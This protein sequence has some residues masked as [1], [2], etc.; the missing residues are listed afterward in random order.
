MG[1]HI[2]IWGTPILLNKGWPKKS[3]V[4]QGAPRR[5]GGGGCCLNCSACVRARWPKKPILECISTFCGKEEMDFSPSFFGPP[6]RREGGVPPE[7][8]D[9]LHMRML[10]SL[11]CSARMDFLSPPLGLRA[12]LYRQTCKNP[13]APLDTLALVCTIMLGNLSKPK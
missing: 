10:F 2:L 5:G 9:L 13:P 1:K 7:L 6:S 8:M 4:L 3:H 11:L 12:T